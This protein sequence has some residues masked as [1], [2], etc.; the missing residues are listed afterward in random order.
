MKHC[1]LQIV[2]RPLV[3]SA[4]SAAVGLFKVHLTPFMSAVIASL[5]PEA[6][7]AV[8][9]HLSG[10]GQSVCVRVSDNVPNYFLLFLMKCMGF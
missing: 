6:G 1:V 5:H 10:L 8:Q 3:S 2:I 4:S 7:T 9:M